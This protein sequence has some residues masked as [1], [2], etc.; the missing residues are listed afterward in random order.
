M[1][2]RIREVLARTWEVPVEDIPPDASPEN[3]KGWDSLRHLELMLEL[4]LEF[5]VRMSAEEIPDLL[6][7][8][9]IESVLLTHGAA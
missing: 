4:E 8:D 1:H 3:L 9:A 7:I 6:S 2:D 5:A